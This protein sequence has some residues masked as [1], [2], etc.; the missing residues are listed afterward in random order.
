M[1]SEI[2]EFIEVTWIGYIYLILVA[3]IILIWIHFRLYEIFGIVGSILILCF[4]FIVSPILLF[5]YL[6]NKKIR[7]NIEIREMENRF[8]HKYFK[9]KYSD[10]K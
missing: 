6:K 9:E 2:E 3:I 1:K 5:R 8:F 7:D 10:K 4:V